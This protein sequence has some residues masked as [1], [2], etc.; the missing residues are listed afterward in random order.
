MTKSFI[1][2]LTHTGTSHDK[3]HSEIQ[4]GVHRVIY[5]Q[6]FEVNLSETDLDNVQLELSVW[7]TGGEVS[8]EHNLIGKCTVAM[9]TVKITSAPGQSLEIS[10]KLLK[11]SVSLEKSLSQN[12]FLT[13]SHGNK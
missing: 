10:R 13:R 5:E 4:I 9:D 11:E 1:T 2:M 6:N 8:D 3:Q 7:E 12:M